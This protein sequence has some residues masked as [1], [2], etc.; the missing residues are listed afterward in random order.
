MTNTLTNLISSMT[1]TEQ[2]QFLTIQRAVA[3]GLITSAERHS[4]T[5]LAR[6][7]RSEFDR[8]VGSLSARLIANGRR[9]EVRA[10]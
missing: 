10:Q 2:A 7:N 3:A 1:P 4:L 5:D 8:L 9:Q 6:T